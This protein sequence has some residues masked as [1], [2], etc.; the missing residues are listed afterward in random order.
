MHKV[1]DL[2]TLSRKQVVSMKSPP[3][4][5]TELFGTGGRKSIRARGDRKHQ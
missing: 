2:R 5:L 4:G 1:R 3:S